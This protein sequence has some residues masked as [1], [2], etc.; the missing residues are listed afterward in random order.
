[1]RLFQIKNIRNG[2]RIVIALLVVLLFNNNASAQQD[3][4]YSQYNNG[5]LTLNPAYAGSRGMLSAMAITR[6]QWLSFKGAPQTQALI[7]H[8]PF[9]YFNMGIGATLMQ[10]NL[11]PIKNVGLSGD[12]SYKIDFPNNRTL[13]LGFKASVNFYNANLEDLTTIDPN[14]P[15]FQE[16][17]NR[18]FIPNF[19]L[20]ALYYSDK[21]YI[22]LSVPKMLKN[23]INRNSVTSESLSKEDIQ[24]L[25][26][27]GYVFDVNRIVKFKP[28]FT[29]RAVS[30]A[31]LSLDLAG[32]FVFY[33]L[34]W[35]GATY[36]WGSAIGGMVQL[37]LSPQIR[38][39]YAYDLT[40]NDL[41]SFNSGTHE[42]LVSFDFNFGKG[43]VRSPRYF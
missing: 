16:S 26:M 40:T 3:P 15:I 17:V 36:R 13:A 29:A 35:V 30:N 20:G 33:D 5:L 1:M 37:Q 14:D 31:P 12:Y 24:Y 42:V 19:G 9:R 38:I 8:S 32:Q 28:Y 2:Y 10:D 22:G 27:G 23:V 34:L 41:Q 18:G 7:I 25:L 43:K 39:G 6:H 21:F 11:G 4:L